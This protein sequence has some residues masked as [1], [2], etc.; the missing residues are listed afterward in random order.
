[1]EVPGGDHW[2]HIEGDDKANAAA[3]AALGLAL[4]QF[5]ERLAGR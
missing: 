4:R 5:L 2:L 1:V 3:A